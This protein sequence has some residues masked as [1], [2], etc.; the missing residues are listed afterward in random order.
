MTARELVVL[1][2][3]SQVPTRQR[4]HNG[5]L[6]RW[7]GE[8]LLFDPGEGTQRQMSFAG[9]SAASIT[10]I[11]LTHFHGDHCL[12]LPG[13]LARLNLDQVTH[14]VDICFPAAGREF[15]CRLRDVVPYFAGLREQP[16]D[17]TG[18]IPLPDTAFE[19]EAIRLDH[20][21]ETFGY[22]LIEP[23]GRRIL[24]DRLAEFGISGP[25]VG[26]LQRE[27]SLRLPDDRVVTLDE[28]ST[29]RRGQRFAFVM[30]TRMCSGVAELAQDADMLVIEA[31][32]LD[33]DAGLAH[34]YGHLTAAQAAQVAQAAGVRTLVLTHFSQRYADLEDHRLEAAKYFDG[35]LVV[36]E[37]LMRVPVPTRR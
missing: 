30:D 28:V 27:G 3:A 13:V 37:D 29:V 33:T 20:R 19:F 15:Y 14:P 36:A 16:V 31:T 12:G 11:C 25:D 24:P 21:V 1:G 2:T 17:A 8:G 32:F 22:R 6:L 34:E 10:R 35:E 9:V 7:D 23:D 4:N 18:A 26:R 5:Y